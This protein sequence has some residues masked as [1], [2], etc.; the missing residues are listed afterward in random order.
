M[1]KVA[2]LDARAILPTRKHAD[3]V[4]LDL[5]FFDWHDDYRHP[6]VPAHDIRI[7][8]TGITVESPPGYF[9]WLTNKSRANYLVGGGIIDNYQGELLVKIVNP[10][11]YPLQ[12][13]LGEAIAQMILLPKH[14]VSLIE[15]PLNEMH[16]IPSARGATGGILGDP[17]GK[18]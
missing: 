11:R 16:Q 10:T 3:D 8:R 14:L 12:F 2:K 17:Y 5:Y 9:W 13:S 7:A 18:R 15:V 4:G 1:I 6:A